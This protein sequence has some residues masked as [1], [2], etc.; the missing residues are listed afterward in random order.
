MELSRR[1]WLVAGA[2]AGVPALL[3][4]GTVQAQETP[5]TDELP[6]GALN[7]KELGNLLEAIGLKPVKSKARYD[8]QFA[9]AP[10]KD[11]EEWTYSMSAV[12]SADQKS[13]WILAWLDELPKSSRDVPR[14]ALLK[15]LAENDK[16][17]KGQFFSYIPTN[18][19]FAL[20]QVIENRELTTRKFMTTLRD[21]GQTVFQTYPIWSVTTWNEPS[22]SVVE[23]NPNNAPESENASE[24]AR[25]AGPTRGA[26]TRS[27]GIPARNVSNTTTKP[28]E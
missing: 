1:Q 13:I 6:P 12:L 14:L 18:K 20:Q 3:A 28:S 25:E 4:G 16:M 15:M 8:F 26:T 2:A 5:A 27:G 22:G 24:N 10:N 11:E 19:R 7:E 23:S 17:G 21:L 9:Y